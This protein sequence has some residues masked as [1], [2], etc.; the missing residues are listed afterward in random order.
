MSKP[1]IDYGRVADLLNVV[2]QITKVAPR[3]THIIGMAMAEVVAI[4]EQAQAWLKEDAEAKAAAKRDADAKRVAAAT[5][6]NNRNQPRT[7]PKVIPSA[8]TVSGEPT[9]PSPGF[10]VP[11]TVIPAEAEA[12]DEPTTEPITDPATPTTIE[13]VKRRV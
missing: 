8:Q 5:A 13:P 6:E 2:E 12:V 4:D 10:A 7:Q 3:C 9:E 11:P 1:D